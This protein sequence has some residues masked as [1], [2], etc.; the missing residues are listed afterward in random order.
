MTAE[1]YV[2]NYII[3]PS[4]YKGGRERERGFYQ[5]FLKSFLAKLQA[6]MVYFERVKKAIN[7]AS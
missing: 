1:G 5:L 4:I 7:D 2:S 6:K 3:G